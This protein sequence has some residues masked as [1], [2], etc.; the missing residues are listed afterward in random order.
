M[1]KLTEEQM[2]QFDP[3][4]KWKGFAGHVLKGLGEDSVQYKETYKAF[5][6]GQMEMFKLLAYELPN[7][8]DD[9]AHNVMTDVQNRLAAIYVGILTSKMNL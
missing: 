6:A 8:E 7:L 5:M 1:N 9:E 2:K 4:E 3:L